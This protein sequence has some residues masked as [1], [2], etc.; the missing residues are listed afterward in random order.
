MENIR[1]AKKYKITTMD[2]VVIR[3]IA[4]RPYVAA[5]VG[6]DENGKVIKG[7]SSQFTIHPKEPIGSSQ[8][9]RL[10]D[11]SIIIHTYERVKATER[12]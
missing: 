5:W 8:S 3:P 11:G 9:G 10:K 2:G 1:Y 4:T 6:R 7:S 12:P